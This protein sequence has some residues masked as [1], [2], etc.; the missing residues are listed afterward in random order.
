VNR[1]CFSTGSW[2]ASPGTSSTSMLSQDFRADHLDLCVLMDNKRNR[3]LFRSMISWGT[4]NSPWAT[5]PFSPCQ[6][7]IPSD[8]HTQLQQP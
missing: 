8:H 2:S 7:F 3:K 1:T 4:S 6:D 5:L